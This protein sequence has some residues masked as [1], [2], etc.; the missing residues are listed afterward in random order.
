MSDVKQIVISPQGL[1][2]FSVTHEAGVD[3]S[4]DTIGVMNVAGRV[5]GAGRQINEQ[6]VIPSKCVLPNCVDNKVLRTYEKVKEWLQANV[7]ATVVVTHR[8][9]DAYKYLNA[10]VVEAVENNITKSTFGITVQGDSPNSGL[11]S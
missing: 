1:S 9:G 2:S 11:Q 6:V 10:N 4:H 5:D 3:V 7:P 8:N